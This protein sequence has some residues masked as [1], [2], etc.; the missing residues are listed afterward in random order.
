MTGDAVG[1]AHRNMGA[2]FASGTAAVMAAGAI[3]G[4]G[5]GDVAHLCRCPAAGV[6]VA[7]LTRG[8]ARMNGVVGLAGGVASRA[9]RRDR[10]A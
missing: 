10:H 5:E 4:R 3:G 1:G 2:G 6:G 8:L 7:T 9:L